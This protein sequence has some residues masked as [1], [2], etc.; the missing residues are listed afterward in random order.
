MKSLR[1]FFVE[2]MDRSRSIG[3]FPLFDELILIVIAILS[4]V[5]T[6]A[7][8]FLLR[9]LIALQ[10]D[11]SGVHVL[12]HLRVQSVRRIGAMRNHPDRV[13]PD[14]R[15][16]ASSLHNSY[17]SLLGEVNDWGARSR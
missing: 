14:N 8:A 10:R 3:L 11:V 6:L 13:V 12:P 4:S 16:M 2:S 17:N 15:E 5:C 9:F 1:S 7:L